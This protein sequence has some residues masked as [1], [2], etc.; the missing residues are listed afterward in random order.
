M[1]EESMVDE[2]SDSCGGRT[3]D[4]IMV[5]NPKRRWGFK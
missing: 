1:V 5:G 2:S 4:S 3:G